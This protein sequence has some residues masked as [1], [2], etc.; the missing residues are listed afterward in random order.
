VN[1]DKRVFQTITL[2]PYQTVQDI[3][4]DRENDGVGVGL[5]GG[6]TELGRRGKTSQ[7]QGV[8]R[9]LIWDLA[10][11]LKQG[12]RPRPGLV[13]DLDDC[14]RTL[15]ADD[16]VDPVPFELA[17]QPQRMQRIAHIEIA[18]EE[19]VDTAQSMTFRAFGPALNCV[20]GA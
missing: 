3:G 11:G 14:A 10:R 13:A 18:L 2:V 7:R 4:L 15:R 9:D 20:S 16:L 17:V 1:T 12:V 8:M 6:A 5:E 19:Q